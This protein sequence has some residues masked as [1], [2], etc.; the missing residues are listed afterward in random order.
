[1]SVYRLPDHILLPATING[2]VDFCVLQCH[3]QGSKVD[4]ID[5]VG[6]GPHVP[7]THATFVG[8]LAGWT[9]IFCNVEIE[10]GGAATNNVQE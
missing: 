10:L 7:E 8:I 4:N 1:M 3:A 2:L 9:K 5:K 6:H